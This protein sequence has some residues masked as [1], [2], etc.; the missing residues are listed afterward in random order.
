MSENK[1]SKTN[2]AGLITVDPEVAAFYNEN[3]D[4]GAENLGGALPLL[5]IV[6]FNSKGLL[7]NGSRPNVGYLYYKPT[8]EQFEEM[9]VSIVSIS[10]G[11][12]SKPSEYNKEPKFTQIVAG[13]LFDGRPFVWFVKG[14][15]LQYIWDFAKQ[16]APYTKAKDQPVPMFALRVMLKTQTITTKQGDVSIPIMSLVRDDKK[17]ALVET[18]LE[19]LHIL[20]EFYDYITP[21]IENIIA[22]KSSETDEQ[23]DKN[24]DNAQSEVDQVKQAVEAKMADDHRKE[25]EAQAETIEDVFVDEPKAKPSEHVNPDEIP[26]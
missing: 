15:A 19:K 5:S 21:M 17:L 3:K 22:N 11:Y 24:F 6:Q 26:L 1:L 14:N 2:E 12:Y 16:A 20:R 8:K 7:A 4:V 9:E 18:N 13:M 25:V 23:V 10:K